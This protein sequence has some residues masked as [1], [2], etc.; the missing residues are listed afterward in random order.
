MLQLI[1]S[2]YATLLE[3][4]F[5]CH[6]VVLSWLNGRKTMLDTAIFVVDSKNAQLGFS[7]KC[8]Y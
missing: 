2:V 7:N 6:C 1:V 8:K 4:A 5:I 3:A